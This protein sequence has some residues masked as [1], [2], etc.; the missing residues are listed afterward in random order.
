MKTRLIST[1]DELNGFV[2]DYNITGIN[3]D[4][5]HKALRGG[6]VLMYE[7]D[8]YNRI[9]SN[10]QLILMSLIKSAKI[11][12]RDA[13]CRLGFCNSIHKYTPSGLYGA[14]L[15][16]LEGFNGSRVYLKLSPYMGEFGEWEAAIGIGNGPSGSLQVDRLFSQFPVFQLYRLIRNLKNSIGVSY[17]DTRPANL[18]ILIVTKR[19]ARLGLKFDSTRVDYEHDVDIVNS[20]LKRINNQYGSDFEIVDGTLRYTPGTTRSVPRDVY[21]HR[22]PT[23]I[24]SYIWKI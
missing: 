15:F 18:H 1:Q 3:R 12:V 13:Y 7:S 23:D 2:S 24:T 4:Q 19:L 6:P 21:E 8:I 10:K 16:S 11:P 22:F 14:V 17:I 5:D 9:I 20:Y